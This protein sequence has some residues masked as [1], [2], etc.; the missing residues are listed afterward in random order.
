MGVVLPKEMCVGCWAL[1]GKSGRCRLEPRRFFVRQGHPVADLVVSLG[2]CE[3]RAQR[4]NAVK[5]PW[6]LNLKRQ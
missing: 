2:L 5:N 1:L 3:V 4:P 6:Y